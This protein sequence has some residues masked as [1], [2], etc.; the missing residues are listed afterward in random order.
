MREQQM[1][2]IAN[3]ENSRRKEEQIEKTDDEENG[4]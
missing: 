4:K 1:E 2:R 3:G